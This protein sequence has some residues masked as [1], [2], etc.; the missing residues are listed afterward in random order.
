[1]KKSSATATARTA[2]KSRTRS[3][4]VLVIRKDGVSIDVRIDNPDSMSKALG[5]FIPQIA[6]A[7][8]SAPSA[9]PSTIYDAHRNAAASLVDFV[10]EDIAKLAPSD[11]DLARLQHAID[12]EITRRQEQTS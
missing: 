8:Q 7:I 10:I 5:C 9:M 3:P 2:K 4:L 12:A 1:M 6:Q 11:G